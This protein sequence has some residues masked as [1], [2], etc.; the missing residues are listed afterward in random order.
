M[1]DG[2]GGDGAHTSIGHGSGALIGGGVRAG[3]LG[4]L[5]SGGAMASGGG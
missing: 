5:S 4:S 1:N 2:D 3:V